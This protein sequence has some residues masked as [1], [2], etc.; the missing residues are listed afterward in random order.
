MK[1]QVLAF[2]ALTSIATGSTTMLSIAPAH[3]ATVCQFHG[4]KFSYNK[5]DF[6]P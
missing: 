1:R 6:K 5:A 2:L 4:L 3:A